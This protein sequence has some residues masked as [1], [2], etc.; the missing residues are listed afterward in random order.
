MHRQS[1]QDDV[2][3]RERVHSAAQSER[4][5]PEG[6]IGEGSILAHRYLL[7]KRLASGGTCDVYQVRD[8]VAL[9]V[10]SGDQSFLAVKLLREDLVEAVGDA[11]LVLN[12]ALLTRQ[13]NHP[14]VIKIFDY[15]CDQSGPTDRHFVT[16]EL[17]EG[18]TLADLLARTPGRQLGYWHAMA[19]LE[20][21]ASALQAAHE[22]GI[23]HSDIKPGNILIG[24]DGQVK[25]IDFG[26]ARGLMHA[27]KRKPWRKGRQTNH[28]AV[29]ADSAR[30]YLAFTHEYASAEVINDEPPAPEDDVY[31][32]ACVIYEALSGRRPG[33]DDSM[34]LPPG[35]AGDDSPELDALA[36]NQAASE[37][38]AA[39]LQKPL[40]RV[41]RKPSVLNFAQWRV[42]KK[43]LS[44][45]KR[46]RYH[47]IS[48]FVSAF[49]KAR[50]LP[51]KMF[52]AM[53]LIPAV[54][55]G[56]NAAQQRYAAHQAEVETWAQSD[57]QLVQAT[58]YAD[59]LAQA[60]V[61]SLPQ[62][63][64]DLEGLPALLRAGVL[65]DAA[66]SNLSRVRD[67]VTDRLAYNAL[68]LSAIGVNVGQADGTLKKLQRTN[69]EFANYEMLLSLVVGLK[70]YYPDSAQLG[71][72]QSQVEIARRAEL[73]ALLLQWEALWLGDFDLASVT[74]LS[75]LGGRLLVVAPEK[76]LVLPDGALKGYGQAVKAVMEKT[77][78]DDGDI[79]VKA[80]LLELIDLF[81]GDNKTIAALKEIWAPYE[82]TVTP[83]AASEKNDA[84][85][86]R[87]KEAQSAQQAVIAKQL[88]FVANVWR[89]VDLLSAP[90]RL[91]NALDAVDLQLKS[92]AAKPVVSA[93]VE[94]IELKISYYNNTDRSVSTQRLVA[95]RDQL[96]ELL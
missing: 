54:V 76:A 83:S 64:A 13:L 66:Q 87:S 79:A 2:A 4:A 33:A 39:A 78:P 85:A 59:L 77:T 11:G 6:E 92:P 53:V 81:E 34:D 62:V 47:S 41:W 7:T 86:T 82:N 35:L 72:L 91:R 17:V 10:A 16:M 42:L 23:V 88:L 9:G 1:A 14:T 15:H 37:Q 56:F 67:H 24:H 29:G 95:L 46:N 12:E 51:K 38:V 20:P 28:P 93:L 75:Q 69:A 50:H 94:R 74:V 32:L 73:Q 25:I 96:S 68:A 58:Q 5:G 31:A 89:D 57:L 90:D 18:E 30:P 3:A 21:V 36:S 70:T 26:T 61:E 40:K 71:D 27:L 65:A 48:E 22:K 45:Q 60:P 43:G 8:L 52:T 80:V 44:D 55:L 63:L 84:N 49:K 19:I